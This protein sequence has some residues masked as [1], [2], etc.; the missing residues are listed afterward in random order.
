MIL[1]LKDLTFGNNE[2]TCRFIGG[3]NT[4]SE[5]V[6]GRMSI[7][8][9][10]LEALLAIMDQ[11]NDKINGKLTAEM[12]MRGTLTRPEVD[13]SGTLADAVAA[14]YPI[15]DVVINGAFI[16]NVVELRQLTG[17]Q[18][19]TGEFS[20]KGTVDIDGPIDADLNCNA[21]RVEPK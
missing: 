9:F 13:L 2:G 16:N 14:G 6:R 20:V 7:T 17:K 15:R 11:K 12:T 8:N 21:V 1:I 10:D 19:E 18:G 4:V 5:T 3:Y